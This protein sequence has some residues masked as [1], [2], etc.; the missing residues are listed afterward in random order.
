LH[1]R[2]Y[3]YGLMRTREEKVVDGAAELISFV[4]H[5]LDHLL[6][7]RVWNIW[8]MLFSKDDSKSPY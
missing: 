6:S 5:S 7:G 1:L 2:L 3:H 8:P 4:V